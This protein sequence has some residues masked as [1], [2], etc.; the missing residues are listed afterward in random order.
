MRD[1]APDVI[2]LD[3]YEPVRLDPAHALVSNVEDA[4]FG[5]RRA[6]LVVDPNF[7]AEGQPRDAG[8]SHPRR[9]AWRHRFAGSRA[10][11]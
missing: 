3:T 7:G 9:G 11:G 5:R 10:G 4:H 6:D 2:H 8:R 1:V